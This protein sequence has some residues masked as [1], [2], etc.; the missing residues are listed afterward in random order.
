MKIILIKDV[1]KIGKRFD[2]KTVSDGHALNLLIPQG[3]AISATPDAIKRVEA[4]KATAE[5][6]KKVHEELLAQNLKGLESTTLIIAG[7]ANPKGHLFAGLHREAI[8]AELQKQSRLQVD[9]SFIM[10]D[11]PIKEVGEHMIEIRAAGKSAMLKVVVR[12]A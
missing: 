8:A 1:P 11:Q 12:E 3:L 2:V 9:P 6:E 7:K 5:A 10:L 4:Q